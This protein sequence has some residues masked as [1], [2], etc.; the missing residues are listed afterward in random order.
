MQLLA[1]DEDPTPWWGAEIIS[2]ERTSSK[3]QIRADLKV[4][5]KLSTKYERK[6]IYR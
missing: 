3:V 2:V 4:G 6:D 5:D 1:K